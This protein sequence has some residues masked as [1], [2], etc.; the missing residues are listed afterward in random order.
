MFPLGGGEGNQKLSRK[1]EP[2]WLQG[3]TAINLEE[4]DMC[5][6]TTCLSSKVPRDPKNP[7][8][9]CLAKGEEWDT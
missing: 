7:S 3:G 4:Q 8:H 1:L 9:S 5:S 2:K 6:P